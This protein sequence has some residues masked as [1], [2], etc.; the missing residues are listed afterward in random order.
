MIHMNNG[1]QYFFPVR[2]VASFADGSRL[3]FDGLT[4][5]QA[6]ASME[7]AQERHGDISFWHGVTDQNYE[8]GRFVGVLAPVEGIIVFDLPNSEKEEPV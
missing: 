3:L 6:R 7:A 5:S 1:M 2:L 8:K 4:E